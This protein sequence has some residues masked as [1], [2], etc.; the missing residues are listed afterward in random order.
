MQFLFSLQAAPSE[1][2]FKTLDAACN[3]WR[4]AL[5]GEEKP[6]IKLTL[7]GRELGNMLDFLSRLTETDEFKNGATKS[8]LARRIVAVLQ[9]MEREEEFKRTAHALIDEGLSSCHDRIISALDQLDLME[10][11]RKAEE[12]GSAAELKALGR[13]MLMLELLQKEV[14]E[15]SKTQ[16]WVDEIEVQLAFQLGLKEKL[17][18]PL[19][20]E[21]MLFRR[22]AGVPDE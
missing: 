18:L 6:E 3:F 5:S 15:Y 13:G 7:G 10:I 11:V 16:T 14:R 9:R 21:N 22:Y 8:I 2:R 17:G 12:Q 1:V 19:A 20:T 4:E